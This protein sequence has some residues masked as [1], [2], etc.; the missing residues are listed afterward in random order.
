MSARLSPAAEAFRFAKRNGIS[1]TVSTPL[2]ASIDS[3]ASTTPGE[4]IEFVCAVCDAAT[5]RDPAEVERLRAALASELVSSD[6]M[7]ADFILSIYF[8]Q[9]PDAAK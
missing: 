6:T 8:E 5:D 1:T 9:T 7:K 3:L 2:R 4:A